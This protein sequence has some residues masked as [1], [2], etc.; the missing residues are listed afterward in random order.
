M[1]WFECTTGA[2]SGNGVALIVT[3]DASFAGSNITA[4]NGEDTFTQQCPSSA[5]YVVTFE[6]IPTGTYTI[7]GVTGG[8]T[9]SKTFVVSDYNF[10][11]HNT[12]TGSTA[13]PVNVIQTW[14]HCAN[15]W[16][17]SYTTINQVLADTSTLLALISS[18]N[19]AD[20]MARST[21][22]A[23]SVCAN[24]TAMGY[25][26]NNNYCA[27]KLLANSTW[28][29]A[30]YNSA[31]M[32]SVLK[33]KVPTMTSNTAPSG[34]AFA[35]STTSSNNYAYFAFDGVNN[36]YWSPTRTQAG[37][38][39]SFVGYDFGSPIQINAFNVVF[40]SDYGATAFKIQGSNNRNSGWVDL[41]HKENVTEDY[42]NA[43]FENNNAYRYYRFLTL[44]VKINYDFDV[45]SIQFYGRA[46]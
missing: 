22:W 14:L 17:K 30:I 40:L 1:A 44:G 36:T 33:V 28:R 9:V 11:F 32:E 45:V 10:E 46:A 37:T 16:N 19:A 34:E 43:T 8:Q 21:N 41:Y 38:I 6:N 42:I 39:N 5:P 27:N 13:T 31:Y 35:S 23:S 3:T 20:Y 7:S 29:N 26:G 18:N 15:I 4:S 25:I 24:Q 2:S 12:P